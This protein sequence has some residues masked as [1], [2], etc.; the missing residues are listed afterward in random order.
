MEYFALVKGLVTASDVAYGLFLERFGVGF[1]RGFCTV[2]VNSATNAGDDVG[3][4]VVDLVASEVE[5]RETEAFLS[6]QFSYLTGFKLQNRFPGETGA[7]FVTCPR[8]H[9]WSVRNKRRTAPGDFA[10]CLRC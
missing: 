1:N 2:S 10:F 5:L 4:G 3:L 7:T 8:C 9:V 6:F